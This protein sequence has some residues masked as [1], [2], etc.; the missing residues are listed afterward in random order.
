ML[1]EKSLGGSGY[2]R[3]SLNST[4]PSSR[5]KTHS[6]SCNAYCWRLYP[7][8][9]HLC[10]EEECTG[11]GIKLQQWEIVSLIYDF[12]CFH[13]GELDTLRYAQCELMSVHYKHPILLIEFEDQKAF[14]LEVRV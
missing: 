3:I 4:I 8:S 2:A 5:I 9:R 12:L 11:L 13:L 7:N 14:S 1:Y 10:R 6:R